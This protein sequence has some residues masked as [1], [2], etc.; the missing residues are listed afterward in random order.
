MASVAFESHYKELWH[1]KATGARPS[2]DDGEAW[3]LTWVAMIDKLI[4]ADAAAYLD[5]YPMAP[6]GGIF[7]VL[8]RASA[9]L[10]GVRSA[11]AGVASAGGGFRSGPGVT[12]SAAAWCGGT[13]TRRA[14]PRS[15]R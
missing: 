14:T 4:P 10:D 6:L 1:Y 11:A 7:L 13:C 3:P 15:S 8:V 5:A 2:I 9:E 12:F